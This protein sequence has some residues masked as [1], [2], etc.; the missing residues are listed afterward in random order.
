MT[1]RDMYELPHRG[2]QNISK[3]C[4][5]GMSM[6][7]MLLVDVIACIIIVLCFGNSIGFFPIQ[8]SILAISI[9]GIAGCSYY[10][11]KHDYAHGS[12]YEKYQIANAM[13][14]GIQNILRML[15]LLML[16]S[17][18]IVPLYSILIVVCAVII[19]FRIT[20]RC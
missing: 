14:Y 2:S 18:L 11:R 7:G 13:I 12:V 19:L 9:S 5:V 10:I 17:V 4:F 3:K 15:L 8:I 16:I 1:E 20:R 6:L